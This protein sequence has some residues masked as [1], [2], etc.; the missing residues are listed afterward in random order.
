VEISVYPIQ[1]DPINFDYN[2]EPVRTLEQFILLVNTMHPA[3]SSTFNKVWDQLYSGISPDSDI[4]DVATSTSIKALSVRGLTSL[5]LRAGFKAADLSH[6]AIELDENGVPTI[7]PLHFDLA[8]LR[9]FAPL[10]WKE[11]SI[12]GKLNELMEVFKPVIEQY[13]RVI[14]SELGF[15]LECLR[16]V[17]LLSDFFTEKDYLWMLVRSI[18]SSSF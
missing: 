13:S 8:R 16:S 4:M 11:I 10:S 3:H 12:Q 18:R 2:D 6:N 5:L 14:T 17:V 15:Q 1:R 9:K 7:D